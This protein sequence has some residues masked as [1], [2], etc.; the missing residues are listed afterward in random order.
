M[1]YFTFYWGDGSKA[2]LQG[3]DAIS[4]LISNYSRGALSALDFYSEGVKFGLFWNK[5]SREWKQKTPNRLQ[6][7][8]WG[9]KTP[10]QKLELLECSEYL[11]SDYQGSERYISFKVHIDPDLGHYFIAVF[12]IGDEF[13][14]AGDYSY[15]SG[16]R[17]VS[18]DRLDLLIPYIDHFFAGEP[19]E[20][21][22]LDEILAEKVLE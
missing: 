9:S 16:G 21:Q 3:N 2:F 10:E 22:T 7:N 1:K 6:Q 13:H 14:Y 11:C 19:V 4:T 5:S 15:L 8:E 17:Y 12:Q 20:L 18:P